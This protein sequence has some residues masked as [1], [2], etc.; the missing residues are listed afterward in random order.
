MRRD[1]GVF[2]YTISLSYLQIYCE[3]IQ[4]LLVDAVGEEMASRVHIRE[5]GDGSVAVDGLT[6]TSV[7][8]VGEAMA[9]FEH[10]NNNRTTACTKMNATSSRSHAALMITIEQRSVQSFVATAS[11]RSSIPSGSK[12]PTLQRGKL[13]LVDLA[14]S[15]RVSTAIGG[16]PSGSFNYARLGELKAINLSLS[17]LGNCIQA[18][19]EGQVS[20]YAEPLVSPSK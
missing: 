17:S 14:G 5:A 9:L 20:L 8:N 2:E 15:E 4:D 1:D 6:L 11:R 18:L 19:A 13:F 10:G 7:R 3:M 16:G 12:N